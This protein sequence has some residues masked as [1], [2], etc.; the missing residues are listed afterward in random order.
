MAVKKDY[1][2]PSIESEGVF[3]TLAA[4]PACTL[5]DPALDGG[6]DPDFGGVILSG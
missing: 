3:E 5:A 2:K 4:T 6:C 1:E